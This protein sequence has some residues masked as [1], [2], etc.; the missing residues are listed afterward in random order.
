M[1]QPPPTDNSSILTFLV[2]A[3]Q[4][5]QARLDD[6]YAD[7]AKKSDVDNLRTDLTLMI[8]AQRNEVYSRTEIDSR[9][10]PMETFM[11]EQR[12]NALSAPQRNVAIAG[13]CIGILTGVFGLLSLFSHITV[14]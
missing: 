11:E 13:G 7:R 5:I 12:K 6:I 8:T 14:H 2:T 9:L 4:A 3:V 10:R 1:L